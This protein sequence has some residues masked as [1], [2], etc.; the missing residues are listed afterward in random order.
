MKIAIEPTT[1]QL[2]TISFAPATVKAVS[3]RV[4]ATVVSKLTG[5]SDFGFD[6]HSPILS[7]PHRGTIDDASR[8]PLGTNWHRFIRK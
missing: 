8:H 3:M 7:F 5:N 1:S 2:Q 4:K 6:I